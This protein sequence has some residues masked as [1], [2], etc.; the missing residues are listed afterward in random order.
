MNLF[1][2]EVKDLECG[3]L[4]LVTLHALQFKSLQSFTG[5]K[6]T[7]NLLHGSQ[8]SNTCKHGGGMISLK[9]QGKK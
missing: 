7:L 4:T 9:V 1:I 6:C 2:S 8:H 3:T 5:I